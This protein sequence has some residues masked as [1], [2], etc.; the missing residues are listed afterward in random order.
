MKKGF[1]FLIGLTCFSPN[2]SL[3][4]GDSAQL[5]ASQLPESKSHVLLRSEKTREWDADPTALVRI[6]DR[7]WHNECGGKMEKLLFWNAREAF[8]S[9]GIGHFI[10]LPSTAQVPFEETFP[11]FIQ[12]LKKQNVSFPTWME[13]PCPWNTRKEFL[14]ASKSK[15]MDE[16]RTLLEQTLSLQ[17][18][19]LYMRFLGIEQ[20][21]SP[22]LSKVSRLKASHQG[23]YALLDYLNFKGSGLLEEERYKGQG[24]GLLQV[25]E[26]MPSTGSIEEA[27]IQFSKAASQVLKRRVANAAPSKNEAHWLVGWLNRVESYCGAYHN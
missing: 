9:L 27:P 8:P 18:R 26:E 13:G 10:W 11:Q 1:L 22:H 6:G 14:R 20:K 25:L 21:L 19:F 2:R 12:F 7:I 24:W 15:E 5:N 3:F 17:I 23:L 4:S 16:L